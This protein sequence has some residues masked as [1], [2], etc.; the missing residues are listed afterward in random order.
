MPAAPI[1][2][3]SG[4]GNRGT[5]TPG[6]DVVVLVVTWRA[7]EF[8]D[9]CLSSLAAQTRPHRVLVIDNASDDGTAAR[10]AEHWPDVEVR[11]MPR[12]L[13]FAG[14]VAAG[15][16]AVSEPLVAL[17]N[18]DAVA[19]PDWLDQLVGALDDRPDAAAATSLV[20]LADGRTVNNAGNV[21]VAGL[22]G[23]D[24]GL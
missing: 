11:R 24:R 17:L 19:E 6:P 21:L 5:G 22:Y 3:A 12:N 20:L 2:G 13:G 18:D 9:E 15:L 16:A 7:R 4:S 1:S 8:I 10:L 14:G 23:A